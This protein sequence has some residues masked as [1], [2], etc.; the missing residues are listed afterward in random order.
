MRTVGKGTR[1]AH[2]NEERWA[3]GAGHRA[4]LLA[5]PVPPY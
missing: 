2:L 4:D 5:L 3:R 1:G